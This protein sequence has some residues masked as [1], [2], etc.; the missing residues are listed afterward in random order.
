M[1][2]IL[3]DVTNIICYIDYILV[4]GRS[5]QEHLKDLERVLGRLQ[6][7]GLRIKYNK[8]AFMRNAVEYLGHRVDA[9][10]VHAAPQ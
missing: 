10:G 8:C 4:T 9:H 7:Y 5:D 3:Q 1:D 6:R 2:S